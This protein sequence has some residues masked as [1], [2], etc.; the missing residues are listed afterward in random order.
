MARREIMKL[1]I[2]DNHRVTLTLLLATALGAP[3]A[4]L[5]LPT[6]APDQDT[7]RRADAPY[8]S[9]VWDQPATPAPVVIVRP[10]EPQPAA[11]E[12]TQSPNPLWEIPLATLSTTRE[13]P[14]F[15]PS[16]RPPPPVVAAAPPPSAPPPPPKLPR[17]ERPQF[18]LVGTVG[19]DEESFGIFVDPTTKAA[20]RLRIG[21]DYQ[22]WKLR[23]VQGRDVMLE[24]DQQTTILSLRQPG[25]GALGPARGQVENVAAQRPADA[26]PQRDPRR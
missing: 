14:I 8:V 9:S 25:A 22:G 16:R 15:S 24:R 6:E 17:V 20:L 10:P 3:A 19:G 2:A 11:P 23:S 1:W 7:S 18:S 26:P 12:R 21:E 5:A 4:T 13:R